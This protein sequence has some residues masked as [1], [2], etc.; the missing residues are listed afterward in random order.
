VGSLTEWYTSTWK[1]RYFM[2]RVRPQVVAHWVTGLG[3]L[4]A[5]A[6]GELHGLQTRSLS[7]R[8]VDATSG[9]PLAFAQVTVAGTTVHT[10]TGSD[11]RFTLS[12]ANGPVRLLARAIGYRAA[13]VEV[14][15]TESTV[16]VKLIRD[17]F[18][19]EELVVSG[20]ETGV[21]RQNL[22]HAVTVVPAGELVAAS[23][24]SVEQS[25]QGKVPGAVIRTNSGAPG[26]GVSVTLRGVT[27][28]I[29]S[30]SPLYVVDGVIISDAT[31]QPGTDVITVSSGG[32]GYTSPTENGVNRVADINP[33]DI[34]TVE[35]LKGASAA[36]IYGSKA[37]GGVI[38][39]TTKRGVQGAP[40]F[41][42]RQQF[43]ISQIARKIKFRRFESLEEAQS[44]YSN[45]A[46]YWTGEYYDHETLLAGGTPL[47]YETSGDVSGGT[48]DMRY[49][50]SVL[51]RHEGG[52]VANTF[53]DKQALR[54]NLDKN[55][56]SRLSF[57]IG[58]QLIRNESDRGIHQNDNNGNTMYGA[59]TGTPTFIDLRRRPDGTFP[60]N[61]YSGS[62]PFET[63]EKVKNN[64]KVWRFIGNGRVNFDLLASTAH[65]LRLTGNGGVDWFQQ[66]NDVYSPPDVQFEG[67]DGLPGTAVLSL[68]D[69]LNLNLSAGAVHTFEKAGRLRATTSFGAQYEF[70]EATQTRNRAQ[71]L[72]GGLRTISA[73]T[74]QN[75]AS[76]LGRVKDFGFYLQEEVLFN[77]R[78]LLTAGIRGDRSSVNADDEKT[79]YYPK[80]SLSYRF[81][82]KLLFLE[83]LKLRVAYGQS[84]NQP[85]FGQK[86]TVLAPGNI[87]GI[88]TYQIAGTTTSPDLRP[89][90]QEE[91][92]GGL[93]ATL[94]GGKMRLELTGYDKQIRD[95]LLSRSLPPSTGFGA[96]ILNAG[97]IRTRGL[98][99]AVT[100]DFRGRN[101][102]WQPRI[103]FALWR[104]KV[105]ELPGG[106]FRPGGFGA[107]FGERRLQEGESCTQ[108][109]GND[110]TPDGARVVGKIG[111][112]R[113]DFTIG[114]ANTFRHKRLNLYFLW[115]WQ[116][117][118]RMMNF[119]AWII[120]LF[121]NT[122]DYVTGENGKPSGEERFANW[123]KQ[124]AIYFQDASYLKLR[125]AALTFR[126]PNS[127]VR[128]FWPGAR[129]LSMSIRG[130]NLL[131]FTPYYRGD[132]EFSQ[133][134][135]A[136]PASAAR[137]DIWAYPPTRSFWLSFDLDF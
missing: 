104:C 133:T 28:I 85:L 9:T 24:A 129:E 124:S 71:N 68:T 29:G 79:F 30:T 83:D 113:P 11:G 121:G 112:D 122:A 128:S 106:E 101:F 137:W 135:G 62:N 6:A 117:G 32:G 5:L 44:V 119:N 131:T 88:G 84:G 53:A 22:A 56:G 78:L 13:E 109:I 12:V 89:E 14:A 110:S 17:V 36:A 108:I 103:N 69:N 46:D 81:S 7:G 98:E 120:D 114:W 45:A 39:I 51:A 123:G 4:L 21:E 94:F 95:L 2:R 10:A 55:V 96:E 41:R 63:A 73:G 61:P 100:G 132:P 47:S 77:D 37:A 34:E 136:G 3:L 105:L 126:L 107:S 20:R 19:L 1:G 125:E 111:D 27:S 91:I 65:R 16:E 48:D 116:K 26:G 59:L 118:G 115:D 99:A 93:D 102:E 70:A 134:P 33:D 64:E 90:R 86:F 87:T 72:V 38:V 67:N 130:R 43:G 57:A 52:I 97:R 50:A 15:A 60:I 74:V 92:E 8:V 66:K 127:F 31:T 82:N 58:S 42:L 76:G 23:T 35:V 40:Q 49:F 25:L 75:S 18:K 54:V 80:A